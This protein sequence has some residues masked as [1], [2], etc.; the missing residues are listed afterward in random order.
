M[1]RRY[2]G[3]TGLWVFLNPREFIEYTGEKRPGNNIGKR[4]LNQMLKE[5]Q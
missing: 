2:R 5:L 3:K 4:A 1:K